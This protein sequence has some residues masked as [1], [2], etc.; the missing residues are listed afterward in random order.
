MISDAINDCAQQLLSELVRFQDRQYLKDP[1]KAKVKRRYICGLREVTKH[2]KQK[3]LKCVIVPPNLDKIQSTGREGLLGIV[4]HHFS[5]E[6]FLK[7]HSNDVM[8]VTLCG[9]C[10]AVMM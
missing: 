10:M 2:L 7:A 9:Q 5:L 3:K 1:V 6:T 4:T 8:P